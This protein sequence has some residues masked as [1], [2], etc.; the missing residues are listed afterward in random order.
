MGAGGG[1]G[2]GPGPQPALSHNYRSQSPVL[3]ALMHRYPWMS[4]DI[5]DHIWKCMNIHEYAWTLL[6]YGMKIQKNV[7][8]L[9]WYWT[10]SCIGMLDNL[11][12]CCASQTP[13]PKHACR[14]PTRHVPFPRSSKQV[15]E[16]RHLLGPGMGGVASPAIDSGVPGLD[17]IRI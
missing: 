7:G 5:H 8:G 12:S 9:S 14:S 3:P 13:S 10:Q 17:L 16:I 2:P 6:G 11:K 1:L 4:I 15:N